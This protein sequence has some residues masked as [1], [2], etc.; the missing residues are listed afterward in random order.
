MGKNSDIVIKVLILNVPKG[1]SVGTLPSLACPISSGATDDAI[2]LGFLTTG[3]AGYQIRT[4]ED[5]KVHDSPIQGRISEDH[6][7]TL[8]RA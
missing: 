6:I 5:P 4:E 2:L 3:Y 8:T 7:K 1:S